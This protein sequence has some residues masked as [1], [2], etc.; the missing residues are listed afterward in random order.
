MGTFLWLKTRNKIFTAILG[1]VAIGL[2]LSV[3][4]QEWFDRMNTIKTYETDPSAMGRINAWKM[5]FNMAKD[6]PLGGGFDAFHDYSFAL[7]APN[8]GDVHDSHSIYF[9][10]LGE[11]GFVGLALFLMLGLMTWRTASWVIGRARRDREKRWV[12]DLAA[13][14]QVSLVGY[15]TAGA[16][17]GLAYFDY[18][19]TLIALVVLC[20]TVLVSGTAD[21]VAVPATAA[22][23]PPLVGGAAITPG[24]SAFKPSRPTGSTR[25]GRG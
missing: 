5:A 1:I 8:P 9:E 24:W 18:Y 23:Q 15:A 22:S 14:I 21:K 3:M 10:V 2:V 13:M 6:R 20:K 17:L 12:A 4:P 25:E 16:F 19:Y 11:Q 7:Y